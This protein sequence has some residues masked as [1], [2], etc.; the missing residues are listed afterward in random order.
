MKTEF[1]SRDAA[2]LIFGEDVIN[3]LPFGERSSVGIGFDT[4]IFECDMVDHGQVIE[5]ITADYS[6]PEGPSCPAL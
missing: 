3:A 6:Y 1:L 4:H 2:E 5:V